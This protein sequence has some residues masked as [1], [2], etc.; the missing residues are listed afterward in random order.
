MNWMDKQLRRLT[1]KK[2]KDDTMPLLQIKKH[3]PSVCSGDIKSINFI[4]KR[5]DQ[6]NQ[7]T[8]SSVTICQT[9]SP[10]LPWYNNAGGS[11]G[12]VVLNDLI[13][14]IDKPPI[15][16]NSLEC[17]EFLKSLNAQLFH[18]KDRD[19]NGIVYIDMK[20]IVKCTFNI[21]LSQKT[22]GYVLFQIIHCINFGQLTVIINNKYLSIEFHKLLNNLIEIN[23]VIIREY[24]NR[25]RLLNKCILFK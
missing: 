13:N 23:H 11:Y 5:I 15:P 22:S 7:L 12:N 3:C 8:R 2:R 10:Q 1:G 16:L 18:P 6:L 14:I 9:S 21:V 4:K 20:N 25:C 24:Y 17:K 19:N